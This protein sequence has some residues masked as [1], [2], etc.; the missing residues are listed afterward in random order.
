MSIHS[1]GMAEARPKRKH[2]F[3]IHLRRGGQSMNPTRKFDLEQSLSA[4]K[5]QLQRERLAAID[6]HFRWCVDRIRRAAIFDYRI[7]RHGDTLIS[8][9]DGYFSAPEVL[10]DR[11]RIYQLHKVLWPMAIEQAKKETEAYFKA[12]GVDKR[13]FRKGP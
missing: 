6:Q 12:S 3:H 4:F 10:F 8:V 1:D 13:V 11:L 5:A 2:K 9:F 7:G